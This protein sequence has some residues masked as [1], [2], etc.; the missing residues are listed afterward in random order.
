MSRTVAFHT[1]GCKVNQYDS[2]AMLE[3][4]RAAGY[5]AVPF[6]G[7]ADVYVIN[8]CTVTGTGDRKSMQ[9]ARR[10]CREHP[11]SQLVLCGCLAQRLGAELL[12]TTGAR[13]V[14][15]TQH[16]S[17]IVTLLEQAVAEDRRIEI[18]RAHV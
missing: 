5:E 11:D 14:L 15:G 1:L 9:A 13:L 17:R 10:V 18:G 16:R 7:P 8:T 3:L 4:F 6:S 2:Q 12:E